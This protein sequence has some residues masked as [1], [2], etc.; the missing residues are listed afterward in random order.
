MRIVPKV[1]LFNLIKNDKIN[2]LWN[3]LESDNGKKILSEKEI[4]NWKNWISDINRKH[5]NTASFYFNLENIFIVNGKKEFINGQEDI[6][7]INNKSE[8]V[9]IRNSE[10]GINVSLVSEDQDIITKENWKNIEKI[11]S[12]INIG[13]DNYK[14]LHSIIQF[15]NI[16]ESVIENSSVKKNKVKI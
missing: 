10:M 14:E 1:E 5:H 15:D 6:G 3:F 8:F 7:A 13:L 9:L 11:L 12:I 4:K 2:S 16:N